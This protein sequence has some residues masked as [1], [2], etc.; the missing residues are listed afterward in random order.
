MFNFEALNSITTVKGLQHAVLESLF[1]DAKV[2]KWQAERFGS[3]DQRGWW[4]QDVR[5][6]HGSKIWL[7]AREKTTQ[8]T[9]NQLI[10]YINKALDWI[11]EYG[12][13]AVI[14]ERL[15]N[16]INFKITVNYLNL[17]IEVSNAN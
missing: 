3:D 5:V 14:T 7:L 4:G 12:S 13:F 2:F 8:A 9:E 1:S 15:Q 11:N 10:S 17:N 16:R 6:E